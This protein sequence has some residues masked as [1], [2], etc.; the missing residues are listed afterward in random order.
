MKITSKKKIFLISCI[1]ILI[2]GAI[3]IYYY[4]NYKFIKSD[5]NGISTLSTKPIIENNKTIGEYKVGYFYP[6]KIT[7][8]SLLKFYNNEC[9]SKGIA[10]VLLINEDDKEKGIFFPGIYAGFFYGKITP[11]EYIES[12]DGI[13]SIDTDKNDLTYKEEHIGPYNKTNS[14]K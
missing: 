4:S 10:Y 11:D 14:N 9:C 5:F 1:T 7:K 12:V 2:I 6:N 13:A 8:E 3:S